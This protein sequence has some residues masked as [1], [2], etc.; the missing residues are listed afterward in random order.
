MDFGLMIKECPDTLDTTLLIT[1]RNK[2]RGTQVFER[3]LNYSGVYADTSKL[4]QNPAK[5]RHNISAFERFCKNVS[6][7]WCHK[8][9]SE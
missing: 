3:S 5:N 6:F 9:G 1:S 4:P 2:M 8:E 7:S